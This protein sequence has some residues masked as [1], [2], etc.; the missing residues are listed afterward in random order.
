MSDY[1]LVV[2]GLMICVKRTSAS[3]V[4]MVERFWKS[5]IL[6]QLPAIRYLI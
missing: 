2:E 4:V 5:S 3:R 1:D 6:L